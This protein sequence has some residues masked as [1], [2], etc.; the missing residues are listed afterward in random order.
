MRRKFR[1]ADIWVS[2]SHGEDEVIVAG[3]IVPVS[4]AITARCLTASPCKSLS[5]TL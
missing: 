2:V 4:D 3:R 1:G 5:F